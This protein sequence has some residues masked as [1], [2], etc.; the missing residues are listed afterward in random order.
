MWLVGD[1]TGN[2]AAGVSKVREGKGGG[3]KG[4]WL[5]HATRLGAILWQKM[6]NF[7]IW[8]SD[9]IC[10][11][12]AAPL[13][14]PPLF[15]TIRIMCTHI[16][17]NE[18]SSNSISKLFGLSLWKV[19]WWFKKTLTSMLSLWW[20]ANIDCVFLSRLLT[21]TKKKTFIIFTALWLILCYAIKKQKTSKSLIVQT[22]PQLNCKALFFLF[23]L[24]SCQ[25]KLRRAAQ[26]L[27]LA[28]QP[29]CPH[30]SLKSGV[31]K[32]PGPPVLHPGQRIALFKFWS[33]AFYWS[34]DREI[35]CC[36]V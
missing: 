36:S 16:V 31:G 3:T 22:F 33:H 23:T 30:W 10:G 27:L 29:L 32:L 26:D 12:V 17:N 6:T 21:H 18:Q 8:F 28:L 9:E 14:H 11:D 34:C 35:R 4:D 19:M 2:D 1:S 13:P 20:Q 24:H 5:S 7:N 15:C 25:P